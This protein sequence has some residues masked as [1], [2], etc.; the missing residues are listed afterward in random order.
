MR[1]TKV[2]NHGLNKLLGCLL[3]TA[4]HVLPMLVEVDTQHTKYV[5]HSPSASPISISWAIL[6]VVEYTGCLRLMCVCAILCLGDV[7]SVVASERL[8]R[9]GVQVGKQRPELE[10][11]HGW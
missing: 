7:H 8:R 2:G 9:I 3:T 11:L 4:D 10:L 5:A 1:C 6:G